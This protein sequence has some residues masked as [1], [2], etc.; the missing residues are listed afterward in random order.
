MSPR[1]GQDGG[2]SLPPNVQRRLIKTELLKP[3]PGDPPEQYGLSFTG[4]TQDE[5]CAM[6]KF[7]RGLERERRDQLWVTA[8]A[9][10]LEHI[11]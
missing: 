6:M 8:C 2:L 11:K 10:A 4:L 9:K 1:H 3:C 7:A 5:A